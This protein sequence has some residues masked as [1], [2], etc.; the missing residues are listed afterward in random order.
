MILPLQEKQALLNEIKILIEES[1]SEALERQ[2]KMLENERQLDEIRRMHAKVRECSSQ[3]IND[4]T[5]R[6][7]GH[8]SC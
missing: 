4:A 8:N 6:G 1:A 5:N 7:A 2:R 3:L